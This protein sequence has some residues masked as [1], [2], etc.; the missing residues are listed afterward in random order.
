MT[1]MMCAGNDKSYVM[2]YTHNKKLKDY[3]YANF[4]GDRTYWVNISARDIY[5]DMVHLASWVNNELGDEFMI[6]ID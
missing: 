1:L 3:P 5:A 2:L 4:D 6:A